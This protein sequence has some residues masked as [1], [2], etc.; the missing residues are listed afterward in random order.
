MW[1]LPLKLP[2][3]RSHVHQSSAEQGQ[4]VRAKMLSVTLRCQHFQFKIAV[5]AAFDWI[6]QWRILLLEKIKAA[7]AGVDV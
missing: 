7:A 5:S 2:N 1:H 6:N 3:C 4:N